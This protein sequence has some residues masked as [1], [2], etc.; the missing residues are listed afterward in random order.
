MYLSLLFSSAMLAGVEYLREAIGN[1]PS[2]G[3]HV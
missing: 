3:Q 1:C 2:T